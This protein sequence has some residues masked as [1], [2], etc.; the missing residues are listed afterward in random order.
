[1]DTEKIKDYLILV[2]ILALTVLNAV[3]YQ[4][5]RLLGVTASN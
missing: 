3:P 4:E 2:W 1:M 5:G